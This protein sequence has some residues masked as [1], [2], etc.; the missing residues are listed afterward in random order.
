MRKSNHITI[1][2]VS[3]DGSV[4]TVDAFVGKRSDR[5][6]KTPGC[7]NC[8]LLGNLGGWVI[9]NLITGEATIQIHERD[10][11]P[12]VFKTHGQVTEIKKMEVSPC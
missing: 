9:A 11:L 12:H 6:S 10:G 4:L 1:S 2:I 8:Y 5:R 3:D 7:I